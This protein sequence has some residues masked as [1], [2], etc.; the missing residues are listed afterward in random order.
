MGSYVGRNP[1]GLVERVSGDPRDLADML[2]ARLAPEAERIEYLQRQVREGH[3]SLATVAAVTSRSYAAALL[4]R[5]CGVVVAVTP[6][7]DPYDRELKA[8][9]AA[10]DGP[11][12]IQSSAVAVATLIPRRWAGLRGAFTELRLPRDGWADFQAARSDLLRD[13]DSAYSIGYD[14]RRRA[15]VSH[16]VSRADY[17]Y[18]TRR[19]A[20][21]DNA[22]RGVRIVATPALGAFADY[23]PA[24]TDPA[25]SPLALAARD[26]L[27]LWCD[28]VV[29]RGLAERHG[30]AAF[31]TVALLET[32]I[33]AGR[34]PDTLRTDV[35]TLA[36]SS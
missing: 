28:D 17:D 20:D 22:L 13:P 5:A 4:Q 30:I 31:G 6:D 23:T 7:P 11:V 2:R 36:R 35:V 14:L 15:L 19:T 18:L 8:A 27:P 12:V 3:A 29:I 26:D 33:E 21:T 32:L 9:E 25:L 16:Q 10:L 1:D 24:E 34:L